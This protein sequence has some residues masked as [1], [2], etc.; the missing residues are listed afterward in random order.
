MVRAFLGWL[1][2]CCCLWIGDV[3]LLQTIVSAALAVAAQ[4]LH[5]PGCNIAAAVAFGG[6][7]S[8]TSLDAC[9]T[10]LRISV[11]NVIR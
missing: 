8:I 2:H 9:I 3:A 11:A 4:W 10:H 5:T 6:K 7:T 1:I